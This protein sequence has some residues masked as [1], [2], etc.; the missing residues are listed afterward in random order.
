MPKPSTRP[1]AH[2]HAHPTPA[3]KPRLASDEARARAAALFRA[4]GD[5][6]RLQLIELLGAGERCV[7]ELAEASGAKMST[8]SQQL[9][10]L[11]QERLVTQRRE[12]KHIYYALAD[13][14]IRELAF[15]ALRHAEEER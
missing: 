15:A 3:R 13:N 10:V 11:R 12:G 5:V 9:R 8:L 4:V 6:H 2:A 7:S 14:H 1:A